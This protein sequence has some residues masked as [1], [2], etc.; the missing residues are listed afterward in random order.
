MT[1]IAERVST[2]EGLMEMLIQ[3]SFRTQTGFQQLQEE[4][5]KFQAES[6]ASREASERK[7]EK[8][9]E[10]SERKLEK[11]LEE[12]RVSR[13]ASERK[14]EKS[15]EASERKLEKS[16]EE[17]RVSR[18]AS[19]R[20]LE[21]SLEASERKLEKSLEESRVSREASDKKLEKFHLEMKAYEKENQKIMKQMWKQ[22]GELANKM[23]TIVEDIVA[24]GL[25]GVGRQYFQIENFDY[26][27]PRLELCRDNGSK[28]REFD[29]V[30][31]SRDYFF[32][33]ETKATGRISY[34]S[35]FIRF[36]PEIPE[37]FPLETK[38]RKIVPV[39]ASLYLKEEPIKYLT[40]NKI[41]AMAT[42]DDGMDLYNS[43]LI[44]LL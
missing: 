12:S 29:V 33:V 41:L 32:L 2:L 19:E 3:E 10:A 4:S 1:Q 37:W 6:R 16:L 28:V 35:D 17:S 22:W 7:L 5:K 13:E 9:L 30:A 36:I 14:L 26:F 27:A 8:F 24:P 18:E 23:G 39:F 11:S 25:R 43:Q 44:N 42:R 40:K 20:K 38:G 34:I 31:Y 21:K 15:L